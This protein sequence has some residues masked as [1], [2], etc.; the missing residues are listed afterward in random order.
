MRK[1]KQS[2]GCNSY[3]TLRTNDDID[4]LQIKFYVLDGAY[5]VNYE[6]LLHIAILFLHIQGLNLT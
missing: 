3:C 4:T 2:S 6:L 1:N 5:I